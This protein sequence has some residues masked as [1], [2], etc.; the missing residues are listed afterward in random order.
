MQNKR[1]QDLF[2]RMGGEEF[3]LI[4]PDTDLRGSELAAQRLHALLNRP[5]SDTVPPY[6]CSFGVG[7]WSGHPVTA[8]QSQF[9]LDTIEAWFKRVDDGV[10][11]AKSAGRNRIELVP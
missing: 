10:Y 11:R 4:L 6:T 5:A 7:T 3:M 2:A 8:A 1:P 9:P